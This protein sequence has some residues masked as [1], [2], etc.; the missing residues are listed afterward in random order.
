MIGGHIPVLAYDY[1]EPPA[2]FFPDPTRAFLVEVGQQKRRA[3]A[4]T[5]TLATISQ[6][7][8][9][10]TLNKARDRAGPRQLAS[11]RLVGGA[12]PGA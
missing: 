11:A 2:E 7:V 12:A 5:T 6:A 3:A 1:G 10:E 4:L 9:D 8:K